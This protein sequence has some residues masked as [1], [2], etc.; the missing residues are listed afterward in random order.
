MSRRI[1]SQYRADVDG[2]RALAVMPV[3]LFHAG[4]TFV[5][6]GFVGVDIF[7][8]VSGFVIAQTLKKDLEARRFSILTFYE[9]RARRILPALTVVLVAT[10]IVALC[11]VPPIFFGPF[12]DSLTHA[13]VFV[14][15]LYFWNDAGY[16]SSDSPFRPLLHTWSLA[17]EEQ[18]YLV[19]PVL[20][21][22]IFRFL[23]RSWIRTLAPLG[24]ASLLLS[25]YASAAYPLANFFSLS[26]R[27]WELLLG[28]VLALRPPPP[29]SS[30][31][32]GEAL[33]IIGLVFIAVPV[34][35]YSDRT[36]FPGLA[37]LPPCL[38]AAI[39]I[40]A[41]SGTRPSLVSRT[42]AR[43]PVVTI[44][45]LSYSL[46]LVH[47]PLVV[48]T[49]FVLMRS[50]VPVEILAVMF[51]TF[52]IA[53]ML[54][55]LVEKPLRRVSASRSLVLTIAL[56]AIVITACIGQRGGGLNR[57]LHEDILN[58]PY[59]I[60][61]YESVEREW[62]QGPCLLVGD[63][64]PQDW[65]QNACVRAG[66]T[67]EP[68]LLWGDSFAAHY[69]PGLEHVSV[70]SPVLQYTAQGCPPIL[71][72]HAGTLPNCHSFNQNALAVIK[73]A[74]ITR[75]LL[76]ASWSEYDRKAIQLIDSTVEELRRLGVEIT[77][78][79]QSPAFFM[80]PALMAARL[81]AAQEPNAFAP[82]AI[83]AAEL[84]LVL[85]T[86]VEAA[87]GRFIDPMPFLCPSDPCP[88]RIA[89]KNLYM[90]YGHFTLAGSAYAARGYLPL[91]R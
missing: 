49:R 14:S 6:G 86:R 61:T 34:V 3:I 39:L 68:V 85:R 89:G 90:D 5:S 91:M 59:S 62:R 77:L 35:V 28:M 37:A 50:L 75:A 83:D 1:P 84:N 24:A 53:A 51:T 10:Y 47:W 29:I 41:G 11:V 2:L 58:T 65:K 12:A 54:Y 33:A 21:F 73:S 66:G 79:G 88:I 13:A 4:L 19:A 70:N 8:V 17:I 31:A 67:G 44:G 48:F 27:A 46:Y 20:L 69:A 71:A 74:H 7:F 64:D 80:D 45:L 78:I 57:R 56:V 23:R 72:Y 18:Y 22:L 43:R 52:A 76:A 60:D 87:G 36:P 26:T 16:F 63:P 42:L 15:N 55:V 82:L 32:W 81:G 9:R 30:K 40:H 25:I 38:G